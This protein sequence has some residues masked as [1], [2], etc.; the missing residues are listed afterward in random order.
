MTAA[1]PRRR[2]PRRL[3]IHHTDRTFL[4]ENGL[5]TLVILLQRQ[6][7][8]TLTSITVKEILSPPNPTNTASL[9][10]KNFFLLAFIIIQATHFTEIFC[11]VFLTLYTGLAFFLFGAAAET[12]DFR[13]F[14][15]V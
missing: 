14:E 12:L 5:L 3:H 2:L 1:E 6:P 11:K 13:Y 7:Q 9:T 4:L 10:V 15:A 8:A